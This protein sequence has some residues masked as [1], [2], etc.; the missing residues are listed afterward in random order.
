MLTRVRLVYHT[1]GDGRFHVYTSPDMKGVHVAADSK[2]D[3]QRRAISVV[4]AISER[5]G[6]DKPVVSFEDEVQLQAAE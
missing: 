1:L 3:A 6:R 4:D 5:R 2:A